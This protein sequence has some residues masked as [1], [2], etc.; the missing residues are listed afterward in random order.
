MHIIHINHQTV[1]GHT[2]A[3]M[4]KGSKVIWDEV[5]E[6]EYKTRCKRFNG[7]KR[8]EKSIFKYL[9]SVNHAQIGQWSPISKPKVNAK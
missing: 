5:D 7:N 1:W 8:L 3:K 4:A 2:F 9:R 6:K